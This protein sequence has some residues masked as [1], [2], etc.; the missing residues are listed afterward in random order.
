M[1]ACLQNGHRK[2][3]DAAQPTLNTLSPPLRVAIGSFCVALNL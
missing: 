1:L 2:H 3:R